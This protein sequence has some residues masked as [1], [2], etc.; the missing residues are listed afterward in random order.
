ME[1]MTKSRFRHLP[2]L[3]TEGRLSGVLSI[4]DLVKWI[5]TSQD[6]TIAHLEYLVGA[7]RI[8]KQTDAGLVHY[9]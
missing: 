9:G 5:L 2:V 7:H 1:V 4:G 8:E 6:E 3:N